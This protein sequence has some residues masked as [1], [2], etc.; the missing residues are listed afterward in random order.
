MTDDDNSSDEH[1]MRLSLTAA[2]VALN[3][4]EVPVGCVFVE[5]TTRKVLGTGYN[6]T[7]EGRNGTYH[8]ELVALEDMLIRQG[9]D[10]SIVSN[11]ELFVTCEPCI[12][13][14]AALARLGIKKV[15]F[16]CYNDRFGGNGSILSVHLDNRVPTQ[17]PYPVEAK[18][19]HDEAISIFQLFYQGENRRAPEAKRKRKTTKNTRKEEA[20]E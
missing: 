17:H 12:M 11:C 5:S 3:N 1:F 9:L 18:L 6:K 4:G 16:G 2:E 14:A 8:A 15:H 19:L 20:E 10:P 13:C 7:N